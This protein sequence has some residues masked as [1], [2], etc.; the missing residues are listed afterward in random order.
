MLA[1][2]DEQAARFGPPALI[3][4]Q[5]RLLRRPLLAQVREGARLLLDVGPHGTALVLQFDERLHGNQRGLAASS[6]GRHPQ[7]LTS[8]R[9]LRVALQLLRLALDRLQFHLHA[10]RAIDAL[11]IQRRRRDRQPERISASAFHRGTKP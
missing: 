9:V 8:S 6:T 5:A 11:A 10:L 2:L 3:R 4:L 7:L 1:E